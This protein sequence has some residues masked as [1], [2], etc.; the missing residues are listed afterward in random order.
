MKKIPFI[1][2]TIIIIKSGYMSLVHS[3]SGCNVFYPT[4]H[5]DP[6]QNAA[7]LITSGITTT[8]ATPTSATP[9][10]NVTVHEH[11]ELPGGPLRLETLSRP[12]YQWK[13][14]IKPHPGATPGRKARPR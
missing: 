14:T 8:L 1:E 2:N 13:T 11:L 3:P 6:T 4:K 9:T 12:P 10:R 5:S 7:P